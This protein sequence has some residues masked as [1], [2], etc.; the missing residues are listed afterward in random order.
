MVAKLA[1]ILCTA[2]KWVA[3]N[4]N[5]DDVLLDALG[6]ICYLCRLQL[7]LVDGQR[8]P[9]QAAGTDREELFERLD[10]VLD[11]GDALWGHS[12]DVFLHLLLVFHKFPGGGSGSKGIFY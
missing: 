9:L 8:L 5:S 6:P 1:M 4:Q 10:V 2:V 12:A 11:F 3:V 7:Q